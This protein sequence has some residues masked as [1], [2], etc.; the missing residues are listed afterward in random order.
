M[1]TRKV[2]ALRETISAISFIFPALLMYAAFFIY[3]AANLIRLSLFKWDGLEPMVFVGAENYIQLF[4]D[5]IFWLAFRHNMFWVLGAVF[6]PVT[7]GLALAILLTRFPLHGKILFRTIYFLPQVLSSIT[8]AIIWGWIYNPVYG[9]LNQTLRM[10]GLDFLAHGWLGDRNFALPALFIAWSWIH[11]GFT[12]VIF[13]AALEGIDEVYFDAAKIDG[14]NKFQQ[15]RHILI[16]FIKRQ[17]TTIIVITTIFSFQVFDLVYVLTNGGPN[18]ASLV[19]PLYMLSSAF[20][21][22]KVGYGS[23]IAVALG[24]FILVLSVILMKLRNANKEAS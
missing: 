22:Y 19:T 16:P 1:D 18:R 12:M 3:P 20:R 6:V 23:A 8:V 10:I 17:L 7:F 13:I 24:V 15:F 4:K 9:A 11:Y 2:K 5:S 14:A 21:Y